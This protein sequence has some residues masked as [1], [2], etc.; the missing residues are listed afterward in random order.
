VGSAFDGATPYPTTAGAVDTTHNGDNDAVVTRLTTDGSGLLFST[1]LGGASFDIGWDVAIDSAGAYYVTGETFGAAV[2]EPDFPTTPGAFDGTHN[3]VVDGFVT[4]LA[5]PGSC[6][7]KPVTILGTLSADALSG[8]AGKDVFSSLAGDD[9]I[10]GLGAADT[11][12]AGDGKDLFKGGPGKDVGAGGTGNDTL[13]GGPKAD[14][15]F[16]ERG[17]DRLKGAAGN[18]RLNGGPGKD[19][20]AGGGG[21]DKGPKCEKERSVP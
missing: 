20:C 8:T 7:G 10:L 12:C 17:K 15:L 1:F 16:G 11:A 3:G 9:Q 21:K 6:R 14:R 5:D 13:N 4:R 18:D 2:G 19:T